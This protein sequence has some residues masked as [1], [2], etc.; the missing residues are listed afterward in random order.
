LLCTGFLKVCHPIRHQSPRRRSELPCNGSKLQ[1]VSTTRTINETTSTGTWSM[2]ETA[3]LVRSPL[4]LGT[5]CVVFSATAVAVHPVRR[6]DENTRPAI[7]E[8]NR[9]RSCAWMDE[10][11]WCH[12]REYLEFRKKSKSMPIIVTLCTRSISPFTVF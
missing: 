10:V 6:R 9:L 3:Q 4:P 7:A 1:Q 5:R 12:L 8:Y 11:R 2:A